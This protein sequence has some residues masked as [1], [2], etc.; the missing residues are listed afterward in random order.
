MVYQEALKA[1]N[2]VLDN[3]EEEKNICLEVKKSA[4]QVSS[5]AASML[6]LGADQLVGSSVPSLA[7]FSSHT[8]ANTQDVNMYKEFMTADNEI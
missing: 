7:L 4:P 6:V 3:N 1:I 5:L 2:K 8:F